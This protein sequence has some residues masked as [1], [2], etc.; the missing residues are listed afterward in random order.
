MNKGTVARVP[1]ETTTSH[2]GWGGLLPTFYYEN[3]V[4]FGFC[5]WLLLSWD[6]DRRSFHMKTKGV[7]A[8]RI[9]QFWEAKLNSLPDFASNS[10]VFITSRLD[11][12]KPPSLL[13]D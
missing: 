9:R 4:N 6:T 13:A 1:G 3:P 12:T 5:I 7:V 8:M 10:A 11:S 2:G